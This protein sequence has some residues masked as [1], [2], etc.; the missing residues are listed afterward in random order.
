MCMKALSVLQQWS[1]IH[2]AKIGWFFT[3]MSFARKYG[4]SVASFAKKKEVTPEQTL[5]PSN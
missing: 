3:E 2:V 5:P 1:S 4:Y